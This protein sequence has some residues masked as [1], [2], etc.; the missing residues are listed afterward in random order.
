MGL[1]SFTGKRK[2]NTKTPSAPPPLYLTGKPSS[3]S[4][5]AGARTSC[6]ENWPDPNRATLSTH[7]AAVPGTAVWWYVRERNQTGG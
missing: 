4:A 7:P 1:G 3:A 2:K 5:M 6:M